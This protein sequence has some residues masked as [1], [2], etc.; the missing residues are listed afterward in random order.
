[1][2]TNVI[3]LSYYI[4]TVITK[5]LKEVF[6]YTHIQNDIC[7]LSNILLITSIV[8]MSNK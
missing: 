1:M 4:T 2:Y 6:Y 8:N 3:T 7:A 5:H